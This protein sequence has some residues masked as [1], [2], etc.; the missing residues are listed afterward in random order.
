MSAFVWFWGS[1][2]HEALAVRSAQGGHNPARA[3]Q[4]FAPPPISSSAGQK[5]AAA[6]VGEADDRADPSQ[7]IVEVGRDTGWHHFCL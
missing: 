6:K 3:T 2:A 7:A 1:S 5:Q 4:D